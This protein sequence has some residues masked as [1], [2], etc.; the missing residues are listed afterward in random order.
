[1]TY[2]EGGLEE[3]LEKICSTL[4]RNDNYT[5]GFLM[6]ASQAISAARTADALETIAIRLDHILGA[7]NHIATAKIN[8]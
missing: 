1:M 6:Q 5:P 8:G 7:L 2:V 4:Q 3:G